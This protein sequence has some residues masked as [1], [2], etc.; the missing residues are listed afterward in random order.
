MF[1]DRIIGEE[2]RNIKGETNDMWGE[3][4]MRIQK[5]ATEVFGITKENK[6]KPKNL[7]W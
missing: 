5:M 6:R 2:T 7:W 3:M 4:T 1:K